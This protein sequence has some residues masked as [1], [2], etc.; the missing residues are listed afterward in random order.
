V[1]HPSV[2]AASS[3]GAGWP[4]LMTGSSMNGWSVKDRNE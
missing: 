4:K 2:S 1:P 3:A